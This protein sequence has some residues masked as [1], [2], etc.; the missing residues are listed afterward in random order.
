MNKKTSIFKEDEID[1]IPILKIIWNGK[2]KILLIT[3]ISTFVGFGYVYQLP[4]IYLHVLDVKF[5]ENKF[6]NSKFLIPDFKKNKEYKDPVKYFD[7][8]VSELKDKEEFRFALNNTKKFREN[9]SKLPLNLQK[10]KYQ[11][12]QNYLR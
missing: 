11:N 1:L 9:D 2:T 6:S 4:N 7:R 12:I 3:I 10:K 5:N 8:F